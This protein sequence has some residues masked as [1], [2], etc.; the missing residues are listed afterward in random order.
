MGRYSTD[1][2]LKRAVELAADAG[3]NKSA[4][5]RMS[6]LSRD[7]IRQILT[8]RP[9]HRVRPADQIE[10][11]TTSSY[12]NHNCRCRPCSEAVRIDRIAYAASLP[13]DE[14]ERRRARY[15]LTRPLQ[16][17]PLIGKF[18]WLADGGIFS[19]PTAESAL[20]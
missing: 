8:G 5:A 3:Y 16:L 4:I 15:A 1:E 2:R 17:D 10:H 12:S 13:E 18:G 19:D 6:G 20:G 14:L 7:T 9:H 11:G